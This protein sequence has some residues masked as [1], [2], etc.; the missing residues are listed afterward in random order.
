MTTPRV[1]A[2]IQ[3]VIILGAAWGRAEA[4]LGLGLQ[5]CASLASG[6]IM[7]GVALFFLSGGWAITRSAAGIALALV[8]VTVFKLFDRVLLSLPFGG[9]GPANPIFAFWTEGLAFLAVFAVL[10]LSLTEKRSGQAADAG[11]RS[12]ARRLASPASA[13]LALVVITVIRF[14]G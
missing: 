13:I 5:R 14:F 7:T 8:L 12:A 11:R 4:A 1:A 10:R 2:R 3:H 6:S 9:G